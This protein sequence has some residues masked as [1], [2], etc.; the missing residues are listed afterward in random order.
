MN[1]G[2]QWRLETVTVVDCYEWHAPTAAI[3]NIMSPG[4]ALIQGDQRLLHFAPQFVL[5]INQGAIAPLVVDGAEATGIDVTGKWH[6]YRLHGSRAPAVLAAG[7][8]S[9]TVLSGRDC[10]ALSLFDCP[11]VLLPTPDSSEVWVPA[12]YA[13]SLESALNKTVQRAKQASQ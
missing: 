4:Y 2:E 5:T 10:A 6:G 1:M 9:E 8:P 11:V 7:V 12:S 13:E 3:A